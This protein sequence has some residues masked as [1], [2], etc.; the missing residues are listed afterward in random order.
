MNALGLLPGI[1]VTAFVLL[2]AAV[3]VSSY[4]KTLRPPK[5]KGMSSMNSPAFEAM[6]EEMR[7]QRDLA[8]SEGAEPQSDGTASG[9]EGAGSTPEG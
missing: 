9:D 3:V 1:L 6:M 8:N 4:R 5:Q 7:R 2:G